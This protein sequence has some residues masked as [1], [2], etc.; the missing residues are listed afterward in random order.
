MITQIKKGDKVKLHYCAEE[1]DYHDIVFD[2]ISD[3]WDL[4][5]GRKVV[6]ITSP[7]KDFRGGFACDKLYKVG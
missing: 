3:P 7:E 1:C 4:G 6:R 2:V 5:N